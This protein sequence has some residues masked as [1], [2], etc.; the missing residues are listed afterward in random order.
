M[1]ASRTTAFRALPMFWDM[2]L[3][4]VP[5]QLSSQQTAIR[6]TART[7]VDAPLRMANR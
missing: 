2:P 7:P 3:R 6:P 5:S 1:I 4:L